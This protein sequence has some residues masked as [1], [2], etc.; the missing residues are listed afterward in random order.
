VG[1]FQNGQKPFNFS[2]FLQKTNRFLKKWPKNCE[3]VP[4]KGSILAPPHNRAE[5]LRP[6]TAILNFQKP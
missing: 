5:V 6:K 1:L 4:N 2:R 3:K